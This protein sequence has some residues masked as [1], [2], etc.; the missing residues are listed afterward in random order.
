[1]EINDNFNELH[2]VMSKAEKRKYLF[3]K[4]S[5]Q[6]R[7]VVNAGLYE[8]ELPY[9]ETFICPICLKHFSEG[10]LEVNLEN[11]LTLED[12]PPYSLGGKANALTCKKCNNE[13]GHMI[14]NHLV[15]LLNEQTIRDFSSNTSAHVTVEH[16]GQKVQGLLHIDNEGKI[17]ITHLKKNNHPGKLEK[18]VEATGKGDKPVL[19][20]KASRVEVKKVE[21]AL[22]K[23][24]YILAFE[25]Y[26]YPLIL[27]KAFDPVREQIL[28]P[29]SEIYPNGFWTKQTCFSDNNVGVHFITTKSLEGLMAIFMLETKN[30]QRNGYSVYL[31]ESIHTYIKVIERLKEIEAGGEL[32]FESYKNT[33]YF[34]SAENQR[35]CANYMKKKNC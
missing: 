33:N 23:T 2:R 31:P 12:A 34:N 26:G 8:V 9:A 11:H 7:D 21:V 29:D 6:L 28:N 22:L 27:S 32:S 16:Q 3:K 17:T 4:F 13:S 20:F 1:V 18:Y 35:Q 24:A 14:D 25:H 30:G 15:E 5:Q 19:F 10:D